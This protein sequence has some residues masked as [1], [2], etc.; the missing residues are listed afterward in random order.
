MMYHHLIF[1]ITL[2]LS[3]CMLNVYG[4][5][6]PE[7]R[8]GHSAVYVESEKKVYYIGG[9]NFNKS[10]PTEPNPLSG[11]FYLNVDTSNDFLKF[12]D[13]TSQANLPLTVFH[14]SELGGVNQDLIFILDGAHW[15]DAEKNYVYSFDIKTNQS[16]IPVVQGK[17]P[18]MR[19]GIS[20][21]SY[22]GKIYLF[23]GQTGSSN[24]VVFFNN[25]D[26]FDTINL[27]WQVGSLVNS[28][29][30]RAFYTATLVNG[31]IYYIGGRTQLNVYSPLSE[32]CLCFVYPIFKKSC[33]NSI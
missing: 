11:F 8:V 13:L 31:I 9:Y 22:Q 16:N 27:N 21:V 5:F 29:I 33:L 20:S 14:V 7:T 32:V 30:T 17:T 10:A 4:Q 23:G 24:E 25:F 12:T 26:I 6:I 15:N 2:Y 1:I 19:K 28:P 18:P 3:L